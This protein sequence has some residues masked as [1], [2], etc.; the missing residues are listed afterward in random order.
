MQNV[1]FL[2]TQLICLQ[3]DGLM[4]EVRSAFIDNL[5]SVSWMSEETR[6]YAT[7]K[8]HA[9]KKMLGYPGYILDPVKLDKHYE[10]VH[11]TLRPEFYSTFYSSSRPNFWKM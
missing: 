1:G 3:V 9:V 4:E 2:M 7:E 10:R 11:I 5:P 8:A 6:S